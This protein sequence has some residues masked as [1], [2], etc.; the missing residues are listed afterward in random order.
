M[1][2]Q[3]GRRP[4]RGNQPINDDG[5]AIEFLAERLRS[6]FE[7]QVPLWRRLGVL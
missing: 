2:A 1:L 7:Q 5:D 4:W 3:R 6:I